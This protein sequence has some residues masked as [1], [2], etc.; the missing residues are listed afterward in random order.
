MGSDSSGITNKATIAMW[1]PKPTGLSRILSSAKFVS[2]SGMAFYGEEN[3]HIGPGN[4]YC[5]VIDPGD[6]TASYIHNQPGYSI[7]IALQ[8]QERADMEQSIAQYCMNYM[9]RAG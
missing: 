5:W 1:L 8:Y 6:G 4:T 9:L 7:S 3:G 2:V